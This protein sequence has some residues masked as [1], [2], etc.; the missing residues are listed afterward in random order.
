MSSA[1]QGAHFL[2]E[3]IGDS[4]FWKPR[5]AA[6]NVSIV[7][8]EGKPNLLGVA[9][10]IGPDLENRV[11]GIFD[12]DLDILLG[13]INEFQFL[14]Q[15]DKNDLE[16]TLLASQAYGR[17][18]HEYADEGRLSRF[19]QEIGSTALE[20]I[21]RASREFGCLRLLN[22]RYSHRVDFDKLSP[23]R[24]I[25]KESQDLDFDS[26]RK[27]YS[28]LAA[29]SQHDLESALLEHCPAAAPWTYSQGHDALRILAIVLQKSIGRIQVKED[30]IFRAFRLAYSDEMLRQSNMFKS[31]TAISAQ[32]SLQIFSQAGASV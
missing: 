17:V 8:C 1:F 7:I 30:G 9:E 25:S 24:F 21:E 2:V 6:K 19:E 28:E 18:L 14:A 23:Y 20:Y 26:L 11:V 5:L 29:I 3:G 4:Q 31:L 22:S 15:T 32:K 27:T 12:T 13:K 10:A 16:L